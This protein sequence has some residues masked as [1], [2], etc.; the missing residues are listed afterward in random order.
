LR[1]QS[2]IEYVTLAAI[3]VAMLVQLLVS[4]RLIRVTTDIQKA[5][6]E[7]NLF[8]S[9]GSDQPIDLNM[10]IDVSVDD[11][12]FQG[13]ADAPIVVVVF[14]DYGCPAC[15]Q[16]RD[17]LEAIMGSYEGQVKLVMRDFPLDANSE[18]AAKAAQ[19]ANE[20]GAFWQMHDRLFESRGVFGL[21]TLN[22]VASELE[23]DADEFRICMQSESVSQEIE[24]D[25][26]DGIAYGVEG[27]PAFFINGIPIRGLVSTSVLENAIDMLL[28]QNE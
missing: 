23:L 20:Q 6:T 2:L 4:Y 19:C 14:S 7:L 11:D 26:Q 22:N 3:L 17:V 28:A 10:V 8:L 15:A 24:H 16:A 9:G 18:L 1:K 25:R 5:L 13:P 12:P 27:T 21:E